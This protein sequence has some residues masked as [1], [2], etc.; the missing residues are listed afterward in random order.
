VGIKK[1][2]TFRTVISLIVLIVLIGLAIVFRFYKLGSVPIEL[3]GDELDI[4]YQAYSIVKTGGDY[5]GN[6]WPVFFRSFDE[7]RMPVLVYLTTPFVGIFGLNAW[8]VRLIPALFGCLSIVLFWYLLKK[9][10]ASKT[11]ALIGAVLMGFVP[12]HLHYSRSGFDV[13]VLLTIILTSI[14]FF[15]KGLKNKTFLILSFL[16]WPLAFYTYSTSLVF[17]IFFLPFVF[18][19]FRKKLSKLDKKSLSMAGI[20]FFIVSIPLLM[21]LVNQKASDRFSRISI[22]ED[23]KM[24]DDLYNKRS[25]SGGQGRIYHNKGIYLGKKFLTYYLQSFSPEFL[26][27]KGDPNP[28]HSVNDFGMLPFV[29]APCLLL[30]FY[31]AC[32]EQEAKLKR[33]NLLFFAWLLTAPIASALTTDGGNHAT[34]LFL[35]LPPLLYFASLGVKYLLS[36]KNKLLI[37]GVLVLLIAVFIGEGILYSHQYFFHYPRESWEYFDYGYQEA[38]SY[39][40]ENDS[41]Y[42]QVFIDSAKGP[43]ILQ[44]LY[45]LKIDPDFLKNSYQGQDWQIDV[46]PRFDGFKVGK[47]YFG[48]AQNPLALSQFLSPKMIYLTFQNTAVIPGDWNWEQSSPDG[49]RVLKVVK[50]PFADIPL[51]YL[52]TG[53]RED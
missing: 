13:T 26:F 8:V 32:I 36:F 46:F 15:I 24:I 16:L 35:M 38:F 20:A 43:P 53:E 5:F 23:A 17:S 48:E 29:L 31:A 6:K 4:G 19:I 18:W 40:K 27:I 52:L 3:F 2:L 33:V 12:W 25:Q 7:Y 44:A 21:N 51:I 1:K 49:I 28:R 37:K 14:I 50:R 47:Y 34:R 11:I 41:Q 22:G 39:L 45:W 30:G 9:I 42:D 10:T